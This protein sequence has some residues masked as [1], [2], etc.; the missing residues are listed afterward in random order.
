MKKLSTKF[1]NV[2]LI[3]VFIFLIYVVFFVVFPMSQNAEAIGETI[4]Q[5]WGNTT[6]WAIGTYKGITEDIPAGRRDGKEA[7]LSA[8]DITVEI[9]NEIE[10]LGNGK[11]EVLTASVKLKDFRQIGDDYA[12]LYVMKGE[13]VFSIDLNKVKIEYSDNNSEVFITIPEPEVELFMDEGD[14]ELLCEYES[15]FFNGSAQDGMKANL[16]SRKQII[17]NS[18]SQIENYDYLMTLAKDEAK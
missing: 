11:L 6:G 4:G 3:G 17:K 5:A 1:F 7:G 16:N 18:V 15:P 10:S 14:A 8:E 12:A 9:G 2:I 13:V